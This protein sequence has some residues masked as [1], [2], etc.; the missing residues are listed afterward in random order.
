MEKQSINHLD[1]E[2][3]E[4]ES[5]RQDAKIYYLNLFHDM[6]TPFYG[7]TENLKFHLTNIDR[8]YTQLR[9]DIIEKYDIN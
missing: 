1:N 4:L 3:R 8:K 2:L 6:G 7:D 9:K 5:K